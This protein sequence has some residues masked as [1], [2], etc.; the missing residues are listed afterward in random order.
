MSLVEI[1]LKPTERQLRQFSMM[2]IFAL[3]SILWIWGGNL[4]AILISALIGLV[5]AVVG[6]IFPVV[7]KPLFITLTILFAPI[8]IVVSELALFL[9]FFVV[10]LPIGISFRIVRRDDLNLKFEPDQPTYWQKKKQ[11]QG[12][13]SY[14]RQS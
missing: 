2:F 14:Y 4:G 3:P 9:I 6:S 10:L 13:S 11:P 12:V 8:G 7:V 1:N 5:L